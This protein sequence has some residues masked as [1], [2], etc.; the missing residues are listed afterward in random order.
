VEVAELNA[1]RQDRKDA[2]IA[3]GKKGDNESRFVFI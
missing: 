3:K 2:K 1:A